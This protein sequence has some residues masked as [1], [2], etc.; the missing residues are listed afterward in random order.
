VRLLLFANDTLPRHRHEA[1]V[2]QLLAAPENL[3]PTHADDN[4]AS[5]IRWLTNNG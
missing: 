3:L 4:D 2:G 5:R 1:F